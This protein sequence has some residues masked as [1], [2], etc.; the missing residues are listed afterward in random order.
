MWRCRKC[1][2]FG[3]WHVFAPIGANVKVWFAQ[4]RK[5][6]MDYVSF[7]PEVGYEEIYPHSN[8]TSEVVL[9]PANQA[10]EVICLRIDAAYGRAHDKA[11]TA[12]GVGDKIMRPDLLRLFDMD[13]YVAAG[14]RSWS[15]F[16][17]GRF[18][19]SR[20]HMYRLLKN[21]LLIR[22]VFSE[23]SSSHEGVPSIRERVTRPITELDMAHWKPVWNLAERLAKEMVY[24]PKAKNFL[25]GKVT[26]PISLRAVAEYKRLH[27]EI[28]GFP[29]VGI[30]EE[31]YTGS[32]VSADVAEIM[33]DYRDDQL[34]D[35]IVL[36]KRI[37]RERNARV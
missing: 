4:R 23:P 9:S 28:F 14:Y 11:D 15:A 1:V 37:L 17:K 36:A 10:V 7:A 30:P 33:E 31:S 19:Q 35:V 22:N 29:K 5:H 21:S 13:A 3:P 32:T 18:N 16:F 12:L 24:P 8:E 2:L 27:P 20:V 6:M 25:K 26:L 34:N